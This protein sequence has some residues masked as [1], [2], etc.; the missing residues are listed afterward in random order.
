M[1]LASA[2]TVSGRSR[3]GVAREVPSI[4]EASATSLGSQSAPLSETL[5]V[6]VRRLVELSK[7][8]QDWDSYGSPPVQ[9]A[10]L[11]AA[12]RALAVAVSERVA[13]PFIGP[14]AGGGVQFEWEGD[15][16]ALE[17]AMLPG[18][19]IEYLAVDDGREHEARIENE[20]EQELMVRAL[21]RW[22]V[23]AHP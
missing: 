7:L 11:D 2:I 5:L 17:L 9:L 6:G 16:R 19:A 21:V 1:E 18:G 10:A 20:R 14:V 12:K 13:L 3:L 22:F 15:G 4:P 8:R 23:A